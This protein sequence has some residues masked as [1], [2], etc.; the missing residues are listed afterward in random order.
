MR[1]SVI[2]RLT[3]VVVALALTG[4][5]S[6]ADGW[7]DGEDSG[8]VFGVEQR[9][10][11]STGVSEVTGGYELLRVGGR[12]FDVASV[13][14]PGG[15][16]SL[17]D[18]SK[19]RGRGRIEA[20]R[21]VFTGGGLPGAGLVVRATDT[22]VVRAA[23]ASWQAGDRVNVDIDGFAMPPLRPFSLKLPAPGLVVTAPAETGAI[24]L[25]G[26]D[27][28]TVTWSAA[29]ADRDSVMVALSTGAAR[30]A[31]SG[32]QLRCFFEREAGTAT[33]PPELV[34]SFVNRAS[35]TTGAIGGSV[36][37]RLVVASH[38]QATF[39]G[40][41]DWVAYVVATSVAREQP[42]AVASR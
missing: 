31:T 7:N 1:S 21:A 16:C 19:R 38:R 41:G 34:A 5:F 9:V 13:D 37:G 40:R 26:S 15:S 32:I 17:E 25:K 22:E 35:A 20:G 18:L 10:D 11:P 14:V 4:C 27:P 29:D 42:F 6:D 12:G 28:L 3:G 8:I 30:E 33:I 2:S 39:V 24:A 23:G 36:T